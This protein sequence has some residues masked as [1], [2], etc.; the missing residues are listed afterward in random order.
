MTS[1]I[2]K[3]V[4]SDLSVINK[5]SSFSLVKDRIVEDSFGLRIRKKFDSD[6]ATKEILKIVNYVTNKI[7]KSF[8]DKDLKDVLIDFGNRI[9]SLFFSNISVQKIII[10]LDRFL[11][12]IREGNS[13][14]LKENTKLLDKWISYGFKKEIFYKYPYFSSFLLESHLG[15]QIKVTGDGIREIGNEPC[16]LIEGKWT[17]FSEMESRF[18]YKKSSKYN[19]IFVY[20]KESNLVFTY[21]PNKK[22][23]SQHH[24]YLDAAKPVGK[25]TSSEYKLVLAEAQKFEREYKTNKKDYKHV[26]QIVSSR[27]KDNAVCFNNSNLMRLVVGHPYIRIIDADTKDVYIL[28]YGLWKIQPFSILTNFAGQ[29]KSLD[30]WEYK[31]CKEKVVTFIPLNDEEKKRMLYFCK[32]YINDDLFFGE[33]IVFNFM[34]QNCTSFVKN[35]I[36]FSL[37]EKIITDLKIDEIIYFIAPDILRKIGFFIKNSIFYLK[38]KIISLIPYFINNFLGRIALIINKIWSTTIAFGLSLVALVLGAIKGITARKFGN[39]DENSE[40]NPPLSNLTN[41]FDYSSFKFDI[42]GKLLIW[43]LKQKSTVVFQ[44][45]KVL[46]I[47]PKEI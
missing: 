2:S 19:D 12:K 8:N 16:I 14:V 10:L 9:I 24:P 20:E 39:P 41:W 13:F 25:L 36:H 11:A 33:K 43:Q 28:G 47:V 22:G 7:D 31:D 44:N 6:F 38:R 27:K 23:L 4:H 29:F 37:G 34:K 5:S 46:T 35:L 32:K 30:P 26:V 3:N 18:S 42:P 1:I 15:S 17:K 40:L 45:P 21:L